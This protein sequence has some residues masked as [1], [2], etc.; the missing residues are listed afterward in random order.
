MG[1][2]IF[3][4]AFL[5]SLVNR[6]IVKHE[7]IYIFCPTC[8]NQDQW[9]SAGFNARNLS[10]LNEE[11]AKGKLLFFHDMQLDTNGNKS[12]ETLFIRG[13]HNE[14]GIIQ[15]EQFTQTTAH[16]EKANTY[17]FCMDTTI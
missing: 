9:R 11:Y 3:L 16:I 4:I 12:V 15:S 17:F 1:K 13:R 7:D 2:T 10:Y 6:G 8:D 5:Y 14:T